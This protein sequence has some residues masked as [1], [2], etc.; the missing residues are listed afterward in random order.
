MKQA[1]IIAD[2][3][4]SDDRI[5]DQAFA[6]LYKEYYTVIRKFITDNSGSEEDAAD[7]FQDAL[8]V[9]YDK[10]RDDNFNLNCTIKTFIYSVCRNLWLKKLNKKKKQLKVDLEMK[11][12]ELAADT[13][14]IL[15]ENNQT[16][17]IKKL[18]KEIGNDE[19]R[20]LTYFYFNGL[21]TD[22]VT[23]KM[24]YANEQV[25]R[26]KKS[27]SLKKLRAL[28]KSSTLFKDLIL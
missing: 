13:A 4:A 19:E 12:I 5:V 20:I 11:V 18:L 26:N 8:I 2:L 25:T 10:V 14:E 9:F 1:S 6:V 21:L 16:Q 15:E 3:R 28:I 27:K 17:L 23:K 22:E 24:G 7:I